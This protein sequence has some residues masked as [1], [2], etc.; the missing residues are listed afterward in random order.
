MKKN[1]TFRAVKP[2]KI[3]TSIEHILKGKESITMFQKL[4]HIQRRA[5]EENKFNSF[6]GNTGNAGHHTGRL[7]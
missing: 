1:S 5:N 2:A 4:N 6:D 7:F 3:H